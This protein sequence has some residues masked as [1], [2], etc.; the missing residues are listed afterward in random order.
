MSVYNLIEYINVYSKTSESLRQYYKDEPALNNN[1]IIDFLA[2]NNTI[3]L[4]K[5]KQEVIRESGSGSTK[6]VKIIVSS[7]YLR[8]FWRSFII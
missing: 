6:D 7:K 3:I 8:D 4:F 1:N 2:N 5:I